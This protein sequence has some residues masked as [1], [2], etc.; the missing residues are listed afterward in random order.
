MKYYAILDTNVLV[1]AML[2]RGSVPNQVVMEALN[3]DI[4]PVLNEEIFSE[5]EEVLKRPKFKF[6]AEAVRVFLDELKCRA[7]YS[8]DIDAE[9]VAEK[10][11]RFGLGCLS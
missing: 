5:Y 2:K 10:S 11:A 9:R 6:N 7:I 8:F 1:S 3:G 4:I